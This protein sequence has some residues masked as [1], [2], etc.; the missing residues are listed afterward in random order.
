MLIGGG[1]LNLQ[2][3]GENSEPIFLRSFSKSSFKFSRY[4]AIVSIP[5]KATGQIL[6]L[7]LH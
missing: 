3:V 6:K 7:I 2:T 1:I 5:P 4:F